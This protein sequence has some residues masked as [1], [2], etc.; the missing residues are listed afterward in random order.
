[1]QEFKMRIDTFLK[2][3]AYKSTLMIADEECEVWRS[4]YDDSYLTH[5][6]LEKDL[7]FLAKLEITENLSHGLGY[8]PLSGQ[9][10]GWSHRGIYGFKVGST[11]RKG[12]VHYK[13]ANLEDEMERALEFCKNEYREDIKVEFVKDGLLY[14]SWKHTK[15]H[16]SKKLK[17]LISGMHWNYDPKFGRG[18]WDAKTMEDAKQMAMD[19]RDGIS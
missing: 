5:V 4:K 9:W 16:P 17:E 11:C 8:S 3:V 18:E 1:M 14:V 15:D 7:K 13:A 12:D 2:K 6:G 10:Y 19:Y